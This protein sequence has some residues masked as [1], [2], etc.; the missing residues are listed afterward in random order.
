V[1]SSIHR[2]VASSFPGDGA[3]LGPDDVQIAY[4]G[5]NVADRYQEQ[6]R[7]TEANPLNPRSVA[8]REGTLAPCH[9]YFALMC[10]AT[11][12][13]EPLREASDDAVETMKA[14]IVAE[15]RA[16]GTGFLW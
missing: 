7:Y 2:S 5:T 8:I 15:L 12:S 10:A 6:G 3:A 11:T 14:S 9:S 1:L 16:R 4:A 13:V